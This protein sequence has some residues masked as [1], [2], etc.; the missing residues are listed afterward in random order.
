MS[1]NF[2]VLKLLASNVQ[3]PKPKANL[4]VL[5]GTAELNHKA[6]LSLLGFL[7]AFSDKILALKLQNHLLTATCL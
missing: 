1:S 3:E 4:F 5:A 7:S 2:K 6:V